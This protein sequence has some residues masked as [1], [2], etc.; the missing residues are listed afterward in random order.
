MEGTIIL[1]EPRSIKDSFTSWYKEKLIETGKSANF[2]EKFDKAIDVAVD[3][4][5]TL[6]TVATVILAV[7]PFDGPVGELFTIVA[8]PALAKL[9]EEGGKL[10]K[11]VIIGEVKRNLIEAKI[12]QKDGSSK[13]VVIPDGDVVEDAKKFGGNVQS[14]KNEQRG[15]RSL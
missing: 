11:K 3:T 15:G 2:E 13:S 1:E 14:F 12:V 4:V 6:G 7:C 9:I 10:L 5:Y 8:T